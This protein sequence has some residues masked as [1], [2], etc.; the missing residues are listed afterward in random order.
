MR[1]IV[2]TTLPLFRPAVQPYHIRLGPG[3][4]NEYKGLEQFQQERKIDAG[5][6][7]AAFLYI[8]PISFVRT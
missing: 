6:S 2:V 1:G 7:V 8:W 3:F 4:V 5:P